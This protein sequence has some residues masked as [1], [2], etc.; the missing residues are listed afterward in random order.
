[1]DSHNL[2]VNRLNGQRSKSL[3]ILLYILCKKEEI[4]I[5][6][7]F[8]HLLNVSVFSHAFFRSWKGKFSG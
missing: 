8:E 7:L 2:T 4:V 3:N 1:M 5:K 6:I